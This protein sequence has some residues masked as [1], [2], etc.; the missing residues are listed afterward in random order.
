LPSGDFNTYDSAIRLV[1]KRVEK[2]N[3]GKV[4]I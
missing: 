1:A 4:F 2:I 3:M